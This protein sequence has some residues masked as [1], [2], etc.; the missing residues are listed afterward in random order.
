[1]NCFEWQSRVSDHL[2]GTLIGPLKQEAD[3]HLDECVACN[4]LHQHYRLILSSI[5]G[6]PRASLAA[7]M[8]KS[9][10]KNI[11]PPTS[12]GW[13]LSWKRIPWYV[14]TPIEGSAVI[15]AILLTI[16]SGPKIRT[17]YERG[18][19]SRLNEFRELGERYSM[20]DL[21][22]EDVTAAQSKPAKSTSAPQS[23]ATV[24]SQSD[25]TDDFNAESDMESD[26]EGEDEELIPIDETDAKN[27]RVG[28]N[29]IWRFNFKT[30]SPQKMRLKIVHILSELKVPPTTPDIAGIVAPGG[31]QFNLLLP[32]RIV[33]D[34]MRELQKIAPP[35]RPSQTKAFVTGP[36][37]W[38]KNRSKQKIPDGLTRV[39]IWLSQI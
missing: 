34:L 15:L 10:L 33:P 22:N 6:Q 26:P 35:E 14:R 39:V 18:I 12:I 24:F 11:L 19:E 30:D 13:R 8:R 20:V 17:L 38:Y 4:E 31:I 29:E 5:A 7:G 3:R 28:N 32:R 1:M 27:I 25:G 21:S 2:D 9:P 36:F 37:T 16:T 23:N